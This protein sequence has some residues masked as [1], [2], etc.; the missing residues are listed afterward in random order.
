MVKKICLKFFGY[1]PLRYEI[2]LK[3]LVS[4]GD[5]RYIYL[6]ASRLR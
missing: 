3:Q 5:Y 1:S 2:L 6:A 4:L